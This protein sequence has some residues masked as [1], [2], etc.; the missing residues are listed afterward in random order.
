MRWR[1]SGRRAS[2]VPSCPRAAAATAT[3]TS[4]D[5]SNSMATKKIKKPKPRHT[6]RNAAAAPARAVPRAGGVR[7]RGPLP[8]ELEE[9]EKKKR[10]TQGWGAL[11][12]VGGALAT[13]VAGAYL[14]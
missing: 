7:P 8:A 5:R 1:R 2:R 14:A 10:D 11:K 6:Y 4:S 12:A 9:D 13:T 3:S